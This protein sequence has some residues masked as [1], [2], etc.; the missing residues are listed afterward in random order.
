V[1]SVFIGD[2]MIAYFTLSL[3]DFGH[4][5]FNLG[6]PGDIT[7]GMLNRLNQVLD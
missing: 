6:I 1:S 2:S 5:V 3:Y 4:L 7:E